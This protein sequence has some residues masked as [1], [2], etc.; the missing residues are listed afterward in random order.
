[1][2]KGFERYGLITPAIVDGADVLPL[3]LPDAS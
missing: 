1:M 3:E 2:G